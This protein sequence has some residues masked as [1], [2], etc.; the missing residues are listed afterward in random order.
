M[1]T[2]EDRWTGNPLLGDEVEA[3]Q[4]ATRKGEMHLSRPAVDTLLVRLSGSWTLQG[5]VPTVAKL[6]RQP[7]AGVGVQRLVID[8]RELMGWD[9]DLVTFLRKLA[10]VADVCEQRQITFDQDGLLEGVRSLLDLAAVPERQG[11]RRQARWDPIL[12]RIATATIATMTS[13]AAILGFIGDA[14]VAFLKLL[15]GQAHFH[16]IDLALLRMRS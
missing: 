1:V 13:A 14:F 9:S 2:I 4:E 8:S 10:D 3:I 12:A 11:A 5:E 16:R 15:C 6:Q 7:D